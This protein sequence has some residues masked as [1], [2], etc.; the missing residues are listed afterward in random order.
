MNAWQSFGIAVLVQVTAIS[1]IAC[2]AMMFLQRWAPLRHAM[3]VAALMLVLASPLV[4]LL[5][6]EPDWLSGLQATSPIEDFVDEDALPSPTPDQRSLPV[7][8]KPKIARDEGLETSGERMEMRSATDVVPAAPVEAARRP[9]R[10]A[11][12]DVDRNTWLTWV[13]NAA[14]AVWLVGLVLFTRRHVVA[15]RQLRELVASAQPAAINPIAATE[16]RLA[17]DLNAL[18]P[19]FVSD[20]APMPMVLGCLRPRVVLPQVLVETATVERLRDVLIHECAH[21]LRGDP[22][23]HAAQQAAG[24]TWW[25]HPGVK[26]LNREIARSR[27]EVC[28]NFVLRRTDPMEY[29]QTL[30]DLAQSCGGA[31]GALSLLGLFTGRWTLE[32][33]IAGILSQNRAVATRT[34]RVTPLV[35]AIL[36]GT[37]SVLIGGVRA[38]DHD[39]Q[40]PVTP[41]QPP[42][43]KVAPIP[44]ASDAPKFRERISVDG[45]CRDQHGKRIADARVRVFRWTYVDRP[46]LVAETRSNAEGEFRFADLEVLRNPNQSAG[47]TDLA[48]AAT[49]EGHTSVLEPI[50]TANTGWTTLEMADNPG[51]ISGVVTDPAGKPLADATVF[52]TYGLEPIPDFLSAVTD[53]QGRY[54][55]GNLHVPEQ[56][57]R[58]HPNPD[59][60]KSD[61]LTLIMA[62]S[63]FV[64]HP[65]Y[66]LERALFASVTQ[67]LK[68]QLSPPAII[69]GQVIDEV[70]G[71]AMANAP[72]FAQGV[73]EMGVGRTRTDKAGRY[74]LLVTPDYYNIWSEADDRIA[75]AVKALKA[76]ANK[77]VQNAD[78]RMLR[79]GFVVGTVF[80]GETGHPVKPAAK[81]P[82]PMH[83][84]SVAHYGPARP[85]TGAAVTSVPIQPDGTYRL[86]VAPGRNY[87]YVMGGKPAS[88]Y[89]HVADGQE[90]QLDLRTGEAENYEEDPDYA[91]GQKLRGRGY[92]QV[93]ERADPKALPPDAPK[94]KRAD[95]PTGRLLNELEAHNADNDVRHTD[96]W[97]RTMKEIVDL[98]PSAVPDLIAELDSTDNDRMLRC[99]G[100]MLR[101]IGDQ[102]A[103]PALIRAIPKTLVPSNSDYGLVANDKELVQFVQKYD[104]DDDDK[105]YEYGFHRSI[106]EVFG[107]LQSLTGQEFEEEEVFHSFLAGT[108]SQIHSKRV[109]LHRVAREW[110]DWWEQNA[111]ERIDVAAYWKVNLARAPQ[112]APKAPLA[113]ARLGVGEQHSNWMLQSIYDPKAEQSFYDFDTGRRVAL[114]EKW[115]ESGGVEKHLEEILKWAAAEGFDMMGTEYVADDG[116]TYYAL[117]GIGL[118]AWELGPD[119]WKSPP[120][121]ISTQSMAKEGRPTETWLLHQDP[122]TGAIDPAAI[123]SFY[124]LTREGTPGLLYVG[125]EVHD[126]S[127]KPGG[128]SQGDNELRSIAF[129]KGR[130]FAFYELK[131][132]KD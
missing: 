94:S 17:L 34:R 70:T 104:L 85:K 30:F 75:V 3:G 41:A 43:A 118:E 111:K 115:R 66:A 19:V 126:D 61:T 122:A 21:I 56:F 114:P 119:R 58:V 5:L 26:W 86:R 101:A 87:V 18:P 60:S 116:R 29:A 77:T 120:A 14:G 93:Q 6:P 72:I 64:R 129:R 73:A 97:L 99:L 28:D 125:I 83:P 108:E 25:F 44:P 35:V 82:P 112:Q 47:M 68:I 98:G 63:L 10:W 106:R 65:E 113:T 31:G 79:G 52:A 78:V 15:R 55:I 123:A 102:R 8:T 89:I 107:A 42:A 53:A 50:S 24:I 100:F 45:V 105:G 80:D 59:V 92:A 96:P 62:K 20:L 36:L 71:R 76:D 33:R 4:A 22:W 69:E 91:L 2:L 11:F 16:A 130:R 13:G 95:T 90:V 131:E 88:A 117:A 39:T 132:D 81:L 121:T 49:A 57:K 74:R 9:H 7:A 27:E 128:I 48:F 51:T 1:L 40:E 46:V 54:L 103:V 23:I 110:A 84:R 37:V 32:Q 12:A 124:Y 38:E 67:E 127:L 109:A